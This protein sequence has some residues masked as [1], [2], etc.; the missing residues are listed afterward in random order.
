MIKQLGTPY[1]VA[2]SIRA[3]LTAGEPV[4]SI[5]SKAVPQPVSVYYSNTQSDDS[6]AST[7]SASVE[8]SSGSRVA[9]ITLL[10][11]TFPFWLPLFIVFLIFSFLPAFISGVLVFAMAA[12]LIAGLYY[13]I[14]SIML[15]ATPWA[16]FIRAGQGFIGMAVGAAGLLGS[17]WLVQKSIRLMRACIKMIFHIINKL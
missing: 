10:I 7:S 17:I 1:A 2:N 9:L 13:I 12:A 3:N 5:L 11:I 15:I 6:T 14:S 8:H 4:S 16:I